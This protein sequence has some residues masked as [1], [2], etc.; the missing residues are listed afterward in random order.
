[1]RFGI[2]IMA[3]VAKRGFR[4]SLGTGKSNIKAHKKSKKM[5]MSVFFP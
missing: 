2:S 1:M 3:L 4:R 5:L